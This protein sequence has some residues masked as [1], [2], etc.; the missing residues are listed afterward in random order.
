MTESDYLKQPEMA[1]HLRVLEVLRRWDPIGVIGEGNQD[2]Y[3]GYAVDFINRL[4]HR[5]SVAEIV[6]FMRALV[7]DH[8]GMSS[9][10]EMHARACAAE[11]VDF[12]RSWKVG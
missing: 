11:L 2:E 1:G 8:M 10:D 12:W 5:V 4:D 7:L 6:E 9:F 3:D